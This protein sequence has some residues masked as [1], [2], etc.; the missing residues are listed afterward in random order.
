MLRGGHQPGARIAGHAGS[1]QCS[2]AVNKRVLRQFL[3][4]AHV[5]HQARERRDESRC[6]DA[7]DRV[8]RTA[9]VG[10]HGERSEHLPRT[11]QDALG[12]PLLDARQGAVQATPTGQ[13]STT[14][15]PVFRNSDFCSRPF[16]W[17]ARALVRIA[18]GFCAQGPI[19]PTRGPAGSTTGGVLVVGRRRIAAVPHD[20][21]RA[22]VGERL[23][24]VDAEPRHDVRDRLPRQRRRQ[25]AASRR[26]SAP[27]SRPSRSRPGDRRTPRAAGSSSRACSD[28]DRR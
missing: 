16:T 15:P 24:R 7:P 3:G 10:R 2:S 19:A 28:T 23:D 12:A 22:V 11:T 25:C 5:A 20:H 27:R 26:S 21:R 18:F 6:L 17:R 14:E 4:D 1:G 13:T 8:D 9:C